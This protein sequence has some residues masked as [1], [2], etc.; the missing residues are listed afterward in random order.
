MNALELVIDPRERPV[1]NGTVRRLLP[2]RKRRMVGPFVFADVIGPEE[3]APGQGTDV[4]AHP[5]IGLATVTYLLDG[6]MVHRDSTGAIQTIE[7]GA[8]NWMTAGSGVTHT[9]RSVPEDRERTLTLAGLQLWVALPDGAEDTA[10]SFEHCPASAVPVLDFGASS[11]RLAVGE[12]WTV[13]APVSGAS[14]LLLA[15]ITL[16]DGSPVPVES[17]HQ[18]LGVLALSGGVSVDG[19]RLDEGQL[20]VVP[21]SGA[22]LTG[23]GTAMVLGGDQVGPRHIWWNF[24]HSDL[25]RIESAKA[26]WLAQ[27]FPTVPNDHDPHVPL[28]AG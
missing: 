3:L 11:A 6:R 16:V 13:R 2:F 17:P 18:E 21:R 15:E 12:G 24:V 10:P 20:A 9:E 22:T 27:R 23:S 14:P 28:P 25:D 26:D 4:D 1:G 19:H 8:V 5:H 7:P